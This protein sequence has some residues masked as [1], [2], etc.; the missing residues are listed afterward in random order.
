MVWLYSIRKH[1]HSL[2]DLGQN[3]DNGLLIV[4]VGECYAESTSR[5]FLS[6]DI[7]IFMSIM[8]H[9]LLKIVSYSKCHL[10]EK[11]MSWSD[12]LLYIVLSSY[13]MCLSRD[14]SFF[15]IEQEL[16]FIW[17]ILLLFTILLFIWHSLIYIWFTGS[18][19]C[20]RNLNS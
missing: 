17:D 11:Q 16:F 18:I 20:K 1:V 6:W 7:D 19:T 2:S 10:N 4:D 3:V 13:I 15:D 9:V 8:L 12:L 5:T 14:Y